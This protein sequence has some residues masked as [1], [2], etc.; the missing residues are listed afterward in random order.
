M[1]SIKTQNIFLRGDLT[2]YGC[3]AV[4]IIL[5]VYVY[6]VPPFMILWVLAWL[7]ENKFRIKKSMFPGNKAAILFFLFLGFYLWQICGLIL[8]GSLNSGVERIFKRLSFILFPLVLFFPGGRII[9]NINFIIRLFAIGT[10]I[11]FTFCLA[12]AFHN[13]LAIKDGTWIFNPHPVDFTYENFFYSDRLSTPLHPTYLTMFIILSVLISLESF[14]DQSLSFIKRGLWL[15]FSIIFLIAIYLLSS[16]AG[17]LAAAVVLPFF[18]FYK[19]FGKV[20]GWIMVGS[21]IIL[22]AGFIR[23]AKT[24]DR[25]SYSLEGISKESLNEAFEKDLRH[26][27]WKSALGVIKHNIVLG[28]GAG[29]ASPKLKKEFI[30]RGY[31]EGYY[32]DLNAHN[33]FLEVLLE[34]GLIGFIIFL[35]IPGYMI[36]LAISER[37]LLYGLYI[38]MMIIFFFFESVLN[39]LAGVTF[40]PLFSFLLIYTKNFQKV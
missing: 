22:L 40:F 37:N 28:V 25:I 6:F 32:D 35:C 2:F 24:N 5:P 1:V 38:I 20:P 17:F 27:I 12:N 3:L 26:F 8:T 21:L 16:R 33:E 39:R 7:W 36:Y 30:G 18:F 10:F 31:V 14:F 23:I 9:K 13:S 19:F 11:Y 15:A 4:V 34:N 29:N